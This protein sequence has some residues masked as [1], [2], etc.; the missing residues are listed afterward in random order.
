MMEGAFRILLL[1][2]LFLGSTLGELHDHVDAEDQGDMPDYYF[3][4]SILCRRK[5]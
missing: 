5:R 3:V 1:G 2:I 4:V